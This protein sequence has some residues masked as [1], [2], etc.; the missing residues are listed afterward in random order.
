[1]WVPSKLQPQFPSASPQLCH[2][3]LRSLLLFWCIF[4]QLWLMKTVMLMSLTFLALENGLKP[5]PFPGCA[6][7]CC[8]IAA[9][10]LWQRL[11]GVGYHGAGSPLPE[12]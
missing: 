11:R 10:M 9:V 2:G 7:V 6:A 5:K 1:M 12:L 4:L 3:S 8:Q